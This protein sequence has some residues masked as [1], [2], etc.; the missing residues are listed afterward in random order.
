MLSSSSGL[1]PE[2]RGGA[3]RSLRATESPFPRGSVTRGYDA[4]SYEGSGKHRPLLHGSG[5]DGRGAEG[6]ASKC[7]VLA[8]HPSP[9]GRGRVAACHALCILNS[10]LIAL[11]LRYCPGAPP[12]PAPPRR[13]RHV[14]RRMSA[15]PRPRIGQRVARHMRNFSEGAVRERRFCDSAKVRLS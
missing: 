6:R 1:G 3:L 5:H 11:C 8:I 13:G 10:S 9:G 2:R 7:S 4:T 12:C 14:G 15:A